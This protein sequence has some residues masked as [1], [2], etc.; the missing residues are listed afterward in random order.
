MNPILLDRPRSASTPHPL[1]WLTLTAAFEAACLLRCVTSP[2]TT[3]RERSAPVHP[4]QRVEFNREDAA[5]RLRH[6]LHQLDVP[7]TH[8]R[9]VG[10]LRRRYELHRLTVSPAQQPGY[11]ATLHAGWR[12]GRGELIGGP[13]RGASGSRQVWRTRLAAGAWRAALLAGGRHIRR[14]ILGIRVTDRD[15]AAILVRSAALLDAPAILRPGTG[16]CLVSV[17][18]GP[19][20]DR[21]MRATE[22]GPPS[23]KS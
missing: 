20:R 15:L 5:Q 2:M 9:A 4:P 8:D 13:V 21:I 19:A 10:G 12:R 14:H 11:A 3:R 22:L 7:V 23:P 1:D 17:P 18:H 6:L 16:C